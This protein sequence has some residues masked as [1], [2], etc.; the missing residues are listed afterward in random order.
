MNYHVIIPKELAKE[1]NLVAVPRRNY[2]EFLTWQKRIKSA[3]TFKP[4]A[5]EKKTLLRSRKN[6]AKGNYLTLEELK[7]A[8]GIKD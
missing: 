8:L 2:E 6:V 5:A 3:R 1:K 4:T 7:N